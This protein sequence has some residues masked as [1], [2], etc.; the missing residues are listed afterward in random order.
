[1]FSNINMVFSNDVNPNDVECRH[2]N[3]TTRRRIF[4]FL[5]LSNF[6]FLFSDFF[7][8]T[9]KKFTAYRIIKK[10][11][12]FETF[13]RFFDVK[14]K[15]KKLTKVLSCLT[16]QRKEKWRKGNSKNLNYFL[17]YYNLHFLFFRFYKFVNQHSNIAK[18]RNIYLIEYI[19]KSLY[20]FFCFH[21][22]NEKQDGWFIDFFFSLSAT[23]HNNWSI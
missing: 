6:F 11:Q 15:K 16:N 20:I 17:D 3:H 18:W 10:Y 9:G 19:Y 14:G 7:S 5:L 22:N 13:I 1:M 8:W 12:T 2:G 4:F 23:N 21:P